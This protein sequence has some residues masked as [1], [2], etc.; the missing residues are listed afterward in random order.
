MITRTL[1]AIASTGAALAAPAPALAGESEPVRLHVSYADL[2]LASVAGVAALQH[3]IAAAV[4]TVCD[5][6]AGGIVT[7]REELAVA[8]CRAQA[9]ADT[10]RRVAALVS[11]SA[12]LASAH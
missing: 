1:I 8:R 6:R 10:D 11:Q 7:L 12:R 3:R 5:A 9:K 2:N 4:N